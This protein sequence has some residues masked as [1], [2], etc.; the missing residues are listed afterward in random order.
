MMKQSTNHI[1]NLI[2]MMLLFSI[3]RCLLVTSHA[4]PV[5]SAPSTPSIKIGDYVRFGK[6]NG[7]A[8]VWSVIHKHSA[9]RFYL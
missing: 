3:F 9:D 6:Y 5:N 8:I 4:H 1:T 7:Q 2:R